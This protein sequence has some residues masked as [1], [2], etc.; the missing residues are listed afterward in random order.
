MSVSIFLEPDQRRYSAEGYRRWYR[1]NH[2]RPIAGSV[3]FDVGESERNGI[4][5]LE[6]SHKVP[7]YTDTVRHMN[8]F[9]VHNGAWIDVHVSMGRYDPPDRAYFDAVFD[10]LQ[11]VPP[12]G[13]RV[14]A[15][16]QVD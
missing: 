14:P 16:Q 5:V 2:L 13:P 7:G 12:D 11:I 10:S 3:P 8:A 4:P 1:E 15:L 6:Y 9:L